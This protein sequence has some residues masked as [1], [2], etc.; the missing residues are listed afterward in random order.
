LQRLS[1]CVLLQCIP[2]IYAFPKQTPAHRFPESGQTTEQNPAKL[3]N[4]F[5]L[6]PF[7]SEKHRS[8]LWVTQQN[9]VLNLWVTQ[10]NG[11]LNLWV[12]QQNGVLNLWGTQQ[13]G[14]LNL[15]GMNFFV[16]LQSKH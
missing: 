15:W 4:G 16:F 13:N 7:C 1:P 14:V 8:N 12:T 9:C 5:R 11:V 10:Q 2:A 6:P 3:P